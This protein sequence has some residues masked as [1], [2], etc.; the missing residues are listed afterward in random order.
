MP[1]PGTTRRRTAALWVWLLG[2][3]AAAAAS[4][5]IMPLDQ[6]K[7]GM[8]GKGRTV[9]AGSAVEEFEVEILGILRNTNPKRDIIIA[10]LSGHPA[11]AGGGIISGMSGSPVLIDGKIIGA[12][13][14]GFAFSKEPI[15][16]ITPIGEMLAIPGPA[17]EPPPPAK[18]P[19]LP[20]AA[21]MTAE[22]LLSGAGAGLGPAA[23]G[24]AGWTPLKVPLI[25]SGFGPAQAERFRSQWEPR[26]FLPQ[27]GGG[28]AP[29]KLLPADMTLREG[30]AVA[31][32]LVTGDLDVS[33]VGTVTYVDGGTVLAFGHPLYNLGSAA[34]GMAKAKVITVVPALDTPT[35][36]AAAGGLV[37]SFIQDRTAGA[38]GLLGRPPKL[39]PVN[40]NLL[41]DGAGAPALREY[42]LNI[43]ADKLLTPL[44]L[45]MCLASLLGAE[46][47]ALGDLTLDLQGDIFLQ[48][49]KSV[50]LEEMASAAM[51]AAVT[52]ISG[53]V[54]AVTYYLT[55]NE[56]ADVGIHR[57]DLNIRAAEGLRTARLER[58]WLDKYEAAPGETILIRVFYR[59]YRGE[60]RVEEIPFQ[61]P[62]LPAGSEFRLIVGDAAAMAQADAGQYR[63][64]GLTPRSLPQ[65][66]RLLGALRKSHRIYFKILTGKPGLFLRGEEMP[67]LPPGMKA[68]FTS[69]R[70]AASAPTEMSLSTLT[71]YQIPVPFVFSGSASVPVRIRK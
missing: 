36:M 70:S 23:A 35:K 40:I 24:A 44:L 42:K 63:A 48:D 34:Y 30:E 22:D 29:E 31:L 57:I 55:N 43:I 19:E 6:V 54:T 10:R 21:R 26:G 50:H 58:V 27:I 28:Q 25:L 41:G 16:G 5:E 3:A 18:A 52:D 14:Y 59:G 61:T 11:L 47:R 9:F 69:P 20:L 68:M 4:T 37:G 65:L 15:A 49:G 60:T 32:Q 67:N 38:R 7:P 12:V 1:R 66:L 33:A 64:Q 39:V 56:W 8:K 51:G 2:L 13:A 53:L 17:A 62:R 45:N 46:Q 71:E